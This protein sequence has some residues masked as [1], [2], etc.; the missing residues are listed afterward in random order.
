MIRTTLQGAA[1]AALLMVSSSGA[2]A[3]DAQCNRDFM[4]DPCAANGYAVV[5][6]E[7]MIRAPHNCM[8]IAH[9]FPGEEPEGYCGGYTKGKNAARAQTPVASVD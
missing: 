1:V 7:R 2:F 8:A 3:A 4:K 9:Y 5:E 6:S